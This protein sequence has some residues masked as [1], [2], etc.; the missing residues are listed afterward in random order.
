M[1]AETS[2]F[3]QGLGREAEIRIC[4]DLRRSAAGS[5]TTGD[6]DPERGRRGKNLHLKRSLVKKSGG[7][8]GIRT[9]GTLSG[10][11]V[12]KT[13]AINHSA[14]SPGA[15]DVA[16]LRGIQNITPSDSARHDAPFRRC[17]LVYNR[18][19]H[20]MLRQQSECSGMKFHDFGE[21]R[22]EICQ[23]VVAGVGTIFV[24][25]AFSL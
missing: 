16:I 9:P 20:F 2:S 12:F 4:A 18:A 15:V 11:P 6:P 19:M 5:P 23:A 8:G 1:V 21:V 25:H 22:Q 13:G 7:E 24:L 14:T 17:W 3:L 10:T